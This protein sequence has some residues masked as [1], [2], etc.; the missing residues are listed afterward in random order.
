MFWVSE[1]IQPG[2]IALLYGGDLAG[3]RE[4]SIWKLPDGELGLPPRQSSESTVRS[5]QS[6]IQSV[7]AIRVPALQPS[8]NSLK[9]LLPKEK[10]LGIFAVDFGGEPKLMNVPRPEWCQPSRLL[11][12]L[13][14]NEAAPGATVQIIGR[15]FLLEEMG[16]ARVKVVL[17]NH[18]G[19]LVWPEV[20]RA[21]KYSLLVVL[22]EDLPLGEYEVWVHNS[23]GGLSGWGS[24]LRLTIKR[25]TQ[26]PQNI[27]NVKDFGAQGDDVADDSE[28]FRLALKAAEKNGGGVVYFSYG[29]Y[30][31]NGWFR[32]PK[33]VILRGEGEDITWLKWPQTRPESVNDFL[34][35]VLY[36]SG[37]YGVEQ[38]SIMV[39]NARIVLRDL[40]FDSLQGT[41][42]PVAE[43]GSFLRP[44][45]ETRDIFLRQVRIHYLPNA[46]RPSRSPE[47]DPQWKFNRWGIINTTSEGLTLAVGGARNVEVSDCDLVGIERLLDLQ[48]ARLV[49]NSFSNQ[50]G[51]SWTDLGGQHLVFAGNRIIGAS[52]WRNTRLP[53]RYLYAADN[54]VQNI[55][56]GEREALVFDLT[57]GDIPNG[58]QGKPWAQPAIRSGQ[59]TV[60]SASSTTLQLQGATF[61]PEAYLGFDVQILSGKGAGQYRSVVHNTTDTL[62]ISPLWDEIPDMTSLVA[63]HLLSRHCILY[64]NRAEDVSNLFQIWGGL[65][66]CIFDGNKVKRSNGMWGLWGWFVQ[67]L[68][69]RLDVAVNYQSGAAW[70]KGDSP[71]GYAEYGITG[72]SIAG[73]IT[74]LPTPFEYVRGAVI[75]GNRLSYG[76]RILVKYGFEGG[77]KRVNFVAARDVVIDHNLIDHSPIGIELDANVEGAV[78]ASNKFEVVKKSLLLHEPR[79]VLVIDA[80]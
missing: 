60:N 33:R 28:A 1:P 51:V 25:P 71:D 59:W 27:F 67:W 56:R 65:Y 66:D 72:F 5:L 4:V 20:T 41:S 38:L 30:R 63:V 58:L 7:E 50:M 47:N 10:A 54:F 32:I 46:G 44:V 77:R 79:R 80:P 29:T 26:W 48:N 55:G 62:T 42:A 18:S 78:V 16:T 69:N 68:N 12:G 15:N 53:L 17:R 22:P 34:P 74:T 2:E 24:G 19:D 43:M 70:P 6:R 75:R 57:H 73:R 36:G 49:R 11:P 61:Q 45:G 13:S 3:A 8:E 76:H 40:S 31:L 9:F 52:S 23:H 14:E 35:A 39:R 37:E 21:E 64:R